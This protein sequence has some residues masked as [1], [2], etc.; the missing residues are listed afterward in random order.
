MWKCV[1]TGEIGIMIQN[2]GS[3]ATKDT[4][5]WM[6]GLSERGVEG[7]MTLPGKRSVCFPGV[8]SLTEFA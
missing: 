6:F 3:V 7:R 1:E 8:Q 4:C 5:L 2:S